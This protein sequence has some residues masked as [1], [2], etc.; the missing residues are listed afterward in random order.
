M[1][2]PLRDVCSKE[3]GFK[4]V[5]RKPCRT[6]S[7]LRGRGMLVVCSMCSRTGFF[8]SS[9]IA[10]RKLSVFQTEAADCLWAHY[11][12]L[13]RRKIP[14]DLT[15][16]SLSGASLSI[17]AAVAMIFLFGM[18][19]LLSLLGMVIAMRSRNAVI[20]HSGPLSK[21]WPSFDQLP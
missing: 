6:L 13:T 4:F 7:R 9:P 3:Q 15:E 10:I 8:F 16:A 11:S 5:Q 21:W 18:V 2:I 14:R 12:P 17:L 1:V 20:T 19:G